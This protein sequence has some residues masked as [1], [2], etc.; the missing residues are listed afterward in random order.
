MSY[1]WLDLYIRNLLRALYTSGPALQREAS[2]FPR[3]LAAKGAESTRASDGGELERWD[4]ARRED[5]KERRSDQMDGAF[6]THFRGS[7]TE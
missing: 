2:A 5:V 7:S 6:S 4:G 3:A 1:Q